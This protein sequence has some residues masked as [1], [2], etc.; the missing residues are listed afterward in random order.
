[1]DRNSEVKKLLTGQYTMRDGIVIAIEEMKLG[2]LLNWQG[3]PN[4]G[5]NAG[6]LGVSRQ[7]TEYEYDSSVEDPLH[8]LM[9]ILI[10]YG[11]LTALQT[12]PDA[13]GFLDRR[14]LKNTVLYV[15]EE[16]M[17]NSFR[18]SVYTARSAASPMALSRATS[19][20]EKE[21]PEGFVKIEVSIEPE[22]KRKGLRNPFRR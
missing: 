2:N 3:M 11:K 9:A 8:A 21:L 20:F 22:E 4:G 18:L 7:V 16:T 12:A 13:V 19:L 17:R 15:L 5:D 6:I 14:T 1:M 10:R